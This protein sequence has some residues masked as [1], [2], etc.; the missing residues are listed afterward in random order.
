VH[1]GLSLQECLLRFV[2]S[3]QAGP[4]KVP[5][6]VRLTRP[7]NITSL[8]LYLQV[9]VAAPAG[10][11]QARRVRVEA[12]HGDRPVGQSEAVE[13]RPP[14]ELGP[15]ETYPRLKVVL[16]EPA[17]VVDFVLLDADTGDVLDSQ[18]GVPN[19]MRREAEDDLL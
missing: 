12:R 4:P 11:A 19:L 7:P 5:V 17:P 9:E 10:P 2:V 14:A 18:A 8:I 13:I 15:G 16:D 6:Q 1:G 3:T